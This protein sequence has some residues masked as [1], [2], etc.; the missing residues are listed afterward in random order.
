M[1]K[2]APGTDLAKELESCRKICL[3]LEEKS[4]KDEMRCLMLEIEVGELKKKNKELEGEITRIQK[5]VSNGEK[6]KG[7]IVDLTDEENEG[8]K[9]VQLLIENKV[10][11]CEKTSAEIE[12]RSWKE[13][14]KELVSRVCELELKANMKGMNESSK[15]I[16]AG[17]VTVTGNTQVDTN[18][19]LMSKERIKEDISVVSTHKSTVERGGKGC[20]QVRKRLSFEEDGFPN[21]TMAPSTPGVAQ[22]PFSGV[23]DISDEDLNCNEIPKVKKLFDPIN[24]GSKSPFSSKNDPETTNLGHIDEDDMDGFEGYSRTAASAKRKR[25]SNTIASDDDED[26]DGFVGHSSKTPSAK[27]KRAARVISSD[28]E[29]SYDDNAPIC[30][31]IKQH[32][33]RLNTDSED[34]VKEG[35][36]KRH[37]KR[38]RKPGFRDRQDRSTLDLN[39]TICLHGN[40]SSEDEEDNDG[41]EEGSES[42][43][44]SLGGFIVDS[45]ESC[46]EIAPVSDDSC[47]ESKD[48]LSDFKLTLDK[49]G[50]KKVLNL[51]W[52]LEGDMLADFGKDPEL[53]MRAVCALYRQQTADEKASKETIYQNE[54]GFSQC[55]ASRASKVAEFLIDG[56]AGGDMSK[57]VEELKRY[58]SKGIKLCMALAAKYSKQLFEIYQNKEDPYFVPK[59]HGM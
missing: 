54:R 51:K 47:D 27:R 14:V 25:T 40:S 18:S 52:D 12:I 34:E 58:D 16:D 17:M 44:D 43:D 57:T 35:V 19:N 1:K 11:E 50:R 13:K 32:S 33:S 56:D 20:I 36:G 46:S 8:D 53:C 45:S 28:D 4:K 15:G 6:G 9:F 31:L 42:E 22:L 30:T 38:L 39:R 41:V 3:E 48:A 26:M 59:C 29:T 7:V 21:K 10:L 2:M 5:V 37:L 24:Y 49:I 23:I 55:D